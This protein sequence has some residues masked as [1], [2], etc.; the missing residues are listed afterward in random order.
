MIR[1][2]PVAENG[3][4]LG[5]ADSN[6]ALVA[7]TGSLSSA[8]TPYAAVRQSV[9]PRKPMKVFTNLEGMS[10]INADARLP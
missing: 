3:A 8:V 4:V 6:D 10:S 7:N 1:S 2:H 9:S 5:S